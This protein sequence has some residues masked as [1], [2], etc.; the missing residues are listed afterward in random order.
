MKR[1]LLGDIATIS[2]GGTPDRSDPNYWGG[3]IPWVKTGEIRFGVIRSAEEAITER[4]INETAAR[5]VKKGSLLMAMYGQGKTRGQVAILG[6]DAAINQACAAI[7]PTDID[8]SKYL[9]HY[10][11]A[12]YKNIRKLSNSGSQ[13]N[14]NAELIR[15]IPIYFPAKP[16]RKRIADILGTWDEAL[17][18]TDALIAAQAR[19][20]Q[21]LMQ[22]LL[23]GK[24]RLTGFANRWSVRSLGELLIQSLGS[25]PNHSS[26]SWQPESAV[27][28]RECF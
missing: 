22:Q 5:L 7:Q 2:S 3:T 23:F 21:A 10:L 1:V 18:K 8:D 28:G 16:E 4:A 25:S 24:V 15:G 26:H 14:L 9:F 17:E 13:E 19:R 12:Q 6:I 20:K 11:A 27:M